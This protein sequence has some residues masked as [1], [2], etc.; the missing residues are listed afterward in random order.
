[1][2]YFSE[3]VIWHGSYIVCI[4]GHNEGHAPS[5]IKDE[6]TTMSCTGSDSM[7]SMLRI[8]LP[9]GNCENTWCTRSTLSP[10]SIELAERVLIYG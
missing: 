8:G 3:F 2:V 9:P 5:N 6:G 4:V 7:D 1:M 10:G